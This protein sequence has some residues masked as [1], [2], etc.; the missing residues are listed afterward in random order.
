MYTT[1]NF[2]I[3]THKIYYLLRDFH[4]KM[5][6]SHQIETFIWIMSHER[7]LTD[8]IRHKWNPT[9]YVECNWLYE[10]WKNFDSCTEELSM[11]DTCRDY[12]LVP[13]NK[14]TH[15]YSFSCMVW[16]SYNH[17]ENIV[18]YHIA[19]WQSIFWYRVGICGNGGTKQFL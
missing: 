4:L 6:N 9:N 19:Q 16:I 14:M 1:N 17:I 5:K 12:R 11:C 15:F 3:S 10:H 2:V 7:L 18:E 8:H 13:Y